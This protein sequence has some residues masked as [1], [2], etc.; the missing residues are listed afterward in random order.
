M[1]EG[2]SI[3]YH[4]SAAMPETDDQIFE[5]VR[6]AI[7]SGAEVAMAVRGRSMR[8]AL[9]PD[10][11]EVVLSPVGDG[12]LRRGDIVLARIA[13]DRHVLHRI[14]AFGSDGTLTL[15]GDGN[16]HM[17]EQCRMADVVGVVSA[18]RDPSG[19]LR[20]PG[21]ACLWRLSRPLRPLIFKLFPSLR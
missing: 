12:R 21:R 18:V 9:E 2:L 16:L 3:I 15:M 5:A 20:R 4:L 6:C 19:R 8:P 14:V 17:R 7:S 1:T 10:A 11:D 13:D